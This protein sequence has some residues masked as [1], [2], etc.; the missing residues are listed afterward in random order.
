[1]NEIMLYLPIA[2]AVFGLV[3]MFIK[4]SWVNKQDAGDKKMQ[5]YFKEYSRRRNGF[6]KSRVQNISHLRGYC[7]SSAVFVSQF[8]GASH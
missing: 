5:T 1:M 3:F 2:L 7:F 4:A 6:L 8:S